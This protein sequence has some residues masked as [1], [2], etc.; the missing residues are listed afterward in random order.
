MKETFSNMKST[1]LKIIKLAFLWYRIPKAII[2]Q[3]CN[4]VRGEFMG[5]PIYACP[6]HNFSIN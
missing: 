3:L 5:K 6:N 1:F 4:A 2:L